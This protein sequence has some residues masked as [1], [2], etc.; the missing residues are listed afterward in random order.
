VTIVSHFF[1]NW[2]VFRNRPWVWKFACAGI[3]PDV[4]Y[5]ALL[6]YYSVRF[7]VNGFTDLAAWNLAWRSP[8]LTTLHSFVPWAA[9]VLLS[10]LAGAQRW[11]RCVPVWAGWL[12]HIV[13]DML[14]HRSDGYP[15]FYP[16]SA[17]RFPTPIS[18]WE[19]AYHGH[20]FTLIDTCLML[21]CASSYLL[22]RA[23][24]AARTIGPRGTSAAGD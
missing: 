24:R 22:T 6:A 16:L 20:E 19:P 21:V 3:A 9:V 1:W 14:T 23:W 5:F 4:P 18:Y 11:R 2:Y 7:G 12:S 13:V 10:G 8:L 15:I 17:Y